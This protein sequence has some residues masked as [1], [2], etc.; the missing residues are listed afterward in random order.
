MKKTLA[1]LLLLVGVV[2]CGKLAMTGYV[3]TFEDF[4]VS[5]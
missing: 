3:F 5:P 4:Q 2:G 1:I